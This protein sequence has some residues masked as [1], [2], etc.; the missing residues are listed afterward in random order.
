MTGV[1]DSHAHGRG[2]ELVQFSG[3]HSSRVTFTFKDWF[4]WKSSPVNPRSSVWAGVFQYLF[5]PVSILVFWWYATSR[6]WMPS[7]ILPSPDAVVASFWELLINGEIKEH[8]GISLWRVVQGASLG[9]SIGL[10]L[11]ILLGTSDAVDS[12]IGPSFRILVQVP[13]IALIP[14]LM[15]FLGIDEKLKIFIMAK[16]CIIPLAIV[17]ADGIRN[18]PAA[19]IEAAKVMKLSRKTL[20]RKV[21]LPGALPSVFTGIRQGVAH[22]WVALVAVELMTSAEG[23]G[24]LMTWSRQIFQIDIVLVC[25][26][27]IGLTGFLLD[28]GVRKLETRFLRWGSV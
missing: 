7:N 26:F 28:Y 5:L 19:Y 10:L 6:E 14:F 21:I 27:L 1:S 17:V 8:L 20:Y 25:I 11:G 3:V 13:S 23:I 4:V 12:W 9:I 16:A 2:R 24:Y 22:V 15:I 18:I